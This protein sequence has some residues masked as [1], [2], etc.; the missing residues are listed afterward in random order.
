MVDDD[1][2]ALAD[3]SP[4]SVARVRGCGFACVG[5]RMMTCDLAVPTTAA[6]E[7]TKEGVK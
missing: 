3:V 6:Y 2:D 5:R 4:S 1:V 7:N